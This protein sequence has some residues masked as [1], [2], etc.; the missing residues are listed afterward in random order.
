MKL[1][2]GISDYI[3]PPEL[4]LIY[5]TNRIQKCNAETDSQ[6]KVEKRERESFI[7]F[8]VRKWIITYPSGK[9][10][11]KSTDLKTNI[12]NSYKGI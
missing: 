12:R 9:G 4:F 8:N 2:L 10:H 5:R 3:F 6:C 1:R 7:N 11:F